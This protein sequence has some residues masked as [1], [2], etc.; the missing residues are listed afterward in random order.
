[1][2][3]NY[4]CC[5]L[6]A[7]GLFLFPFKIPQGREKGTDS[8]K[9]RTEKRFGHFGRVLKTRFGGEARHFCREKVIGKME[10][11]FRS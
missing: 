7:P 5:P 8:L 1:M 9:L 2:C 10:R 4:P 3:C 11:A 6:Q